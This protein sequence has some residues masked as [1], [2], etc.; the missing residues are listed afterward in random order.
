MEL[1]RSCSGLDTWGAVRL[2]IFTADKSA[3][4]DLL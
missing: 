4:A 2:M 3:E 1:R